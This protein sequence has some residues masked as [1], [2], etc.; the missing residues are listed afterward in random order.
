MFLIIPPV[1]NVSKRAHL[2]VTTS[3][4]VELH[5]DSVLDYIYRHVCG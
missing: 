4:Y 2:L 1:N 5:W 3:R